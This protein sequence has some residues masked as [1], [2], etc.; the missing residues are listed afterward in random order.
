MKR[1]TDSMT[2]EQR[3]QAIQEENRRISPSPYDLMTTEQK[4]QTLKSDRERRFEELGKYLEN[5]DDLIPSILSTYAII[6]SLTE[7]LKKLREAK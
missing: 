6:Q 7:S 2:I 4:I 3:M 5:L 1:P